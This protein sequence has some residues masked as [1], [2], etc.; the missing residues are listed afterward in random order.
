MSTTTRHADA[1]AELLRPS[2]KWTGTAPIV[3]IIYRLPAGVWGGR[4]LY[5][6]ELA[7][8][9]T[10]RGIPT[11]ITV[12]GEG[13]YEQ[14]SPEYAA[15]VVVE[16]VAWRDG[17]RISLPDW[18]R[19][20]RT[21]PASVVILP[22]WEIHEPSMEMLMA[23]CYNYRERLVHLHNTV[24]AMPK[25][26]RVVILGRPVEVPGTYRARERLRG[27]IVSTALRKVICVNEIGQRRL[28]E[29][30]GFAAQRTIT[31]HN[32]VDCER[33]QFDPQARARYRQH[34]GISETA[35]V[36][37]AIGRIQ[38]TIKRHDLSLRAFARLVLEHPTTELHFLLVGEG[39]DRGNTLD[40]VHELGLDKRVTIAPFTVRP[41]EAHCA[42]DVFL[43]P[44]ITE[45]LPLALAEAMATERCV[46]AS[47]I[48]GMLEVLARPEVG[49]PVP[50]HDV[51]GFYRAM[52]ATLELG[53]AGR[54]A[55][56]ARA[57]AWILE[58]FSADNQF[59]ELIAQIFGH[60]R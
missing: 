60:R 47:A 42:L 56:G 5:N 25:R 28:V 48:D 32:G 27:R 10:R 8:R 13:N 7:A 21:R 44:S 6:I 35:L 45:G 53:S 37:G 11:V 34:Y 20:M 51:E 59:N 49:W 15:E 54:W 14:M 16:Q 50:P 22:S 46:I 2:Q 30:F 18:H 24:P 17:D 4:E 55:A 38:N 36:F 41:W 23:A 43:M 29:D 39:P 26:R 3:R 57:R 19:I 1:V 52:A 9:L 58:R 31:V 12:V 33:F 40:L